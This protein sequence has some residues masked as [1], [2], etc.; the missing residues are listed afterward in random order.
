VRFLFIRVN[1]ASVAGFLAVAEME[2]RQKDLFWCSEARQG[3]P[4]LLVDVSLGALHG[5]S[6]PSPLPEAPASGSPI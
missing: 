2:C 1:I 5:L 6:S 4:A 3:S